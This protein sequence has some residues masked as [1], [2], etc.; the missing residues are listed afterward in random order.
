VSRSL[1]IATRGHEVGPTTEA[2]GVGPGRPC[3]LLNEVVGDVA[4]FTV[5][6]PT[7]FDYA[8]TLI[9]YNEIGS[10]EDYLEAGPE[11]AGFVINAGSLVEGRIYVFVPW[12]YDVEGNL[13]KPGDPILATSPINIIDMPGLSLNSCS[14]ELI[15][16][17]IREKV[18]DRE[19]SRALMQADQQIVQLTLERNR[20]NDRILRLEAEVNVLRGKI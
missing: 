16:Q 4:S 19:L 2:G 6:P 7:D 13:G 12:S 18:D 11:D 15:W 8:G 14:L 9:Q 3:I 1:A 17:L 5:I 20:Q 10:C